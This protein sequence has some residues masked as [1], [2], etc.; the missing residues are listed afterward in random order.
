MGIV[1]NCDWHL[2]RS[3]GTSYKA[4]NSYPVPSATIFLLLFLLL[5]LLLLSPHPWSPLS[6]RLP[7]QPVTLSPPSPPSPPPP[8]PPLPGSRFNLAHLSRT[9]HSC[10]IHPAPRRCTTVSRFYIFSEW[11]LPVEQRIGK[12]WILN[13]YHWHLSKTF[14]F[15][16]IKDQDMKSCSAAKHGSN[17]L[18]LNGTQGIGT[19]IF[20][21]NK[22][23]CGL[24]WDF[25]LTTFQGSIIY[26]GWRILWGCELSLLGNRS[27]V[28]QML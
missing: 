18:I 23:A 4:F 14:I 16:P 12:I 11:W 10:C 26:A 8:T 1:K 5:L 17:V 19:K 22:E 6:P 2:F 24:L 3:A 21:A 7:R 9:I 25:S 28:L 20:W 15:A 27:E 13:W